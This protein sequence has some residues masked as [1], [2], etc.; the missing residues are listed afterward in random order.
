[1]ADADVHDAATALGVGAGWEK[2]LGVAGAFG[3]S[4][5]VGREQD[6]EGRHLVRPGP[7]AGLAGG[8]GGD[9]RVGRAGAS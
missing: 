6:R 8:D 3:G 4:V 7:D 2:H 1:M 5:P 9:G